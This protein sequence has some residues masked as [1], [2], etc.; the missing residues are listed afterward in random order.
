MQDIDVES[1][2][3]ETVKKILAQ[4]VG[5]YEVW[6]FGSRVAKTARKFSDLDLVILTQKPLELGIYGDLQMA[7]SESDLPFKV[8][9]VD[10]AAT[11]EDFRKIIQQKYVVLQKP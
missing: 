7:F 3:L 1:I 2:D 6:A 10:W 9:I 4:Y 8:D 5:Q 11:S